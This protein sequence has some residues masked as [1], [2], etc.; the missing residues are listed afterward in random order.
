MK[1][2]PLFK[3]QVQVVP[4]E[5]FSQNCRYD[6]KTRLLKETLDIS[7]TIWSFRL[8]KLKGHIFGCG[9]RVAFFSVVIPECSH[10]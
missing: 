7:S 9:L 2:I 4:N 3:E 8:S 6:V 1:G 5:L 10:D